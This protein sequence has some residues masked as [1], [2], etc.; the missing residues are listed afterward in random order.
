M[1]TWDERKRKSNLA[2]HGVDLGFA[3]QFDLSAAVIEE[4]RDVSHEQRFRA[5]GFVGD[6]LYFLVFTLDD[7]GEPHVIS[8]RRAT[9]KER[10]KYAEE[11]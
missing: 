9:P 8:M 3:E 5:I 10:R 4:D 11:T 1:T 6:K 2:K 7:T